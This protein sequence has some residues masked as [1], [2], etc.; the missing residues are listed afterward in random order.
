MKKLAAFIIAIVTAGNLWS[1]EI[2]RGNIYP[3]AVNHQNSAYSYGLFSLNTMESSFR[4]I[5]V[6]QTPAFNNR[7]TFFRY[8]Y[9]SEGRLISFQRDDV[10]YSY[11]YNGNELSAV[12]FNDTDIYFPSPYFVSIRKGGD[13]LLFDLEKEDGGNLEAIVLN[14]E[15]GT[16]Y[17]LQ[18]GRLDSVESIGRG[19]DK[20]A[21]RYEYDEEG[22]LRRYRKETS[23]GRGESKIVTVYSFSYQSGRVSDYLY[24]KSGPGRSFERVHCTFEYID[25][26]E[27]RIETAFAT[28]DEGSIVMTAQYEYSGPND[29]TIRI[30]DGRN[31]LMETIEVTKR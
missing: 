16:K 13:E 7:E 5:T 23:E 24:E 21:S 29:Y 15:N 11:E 2:Y 26:T 4:E 3:G 6:K 30:K 17:F 8:A 22:Q 10:S 28:D 9:D 31:R 19:D 27:G 20:F 14:D 18:E 25:N 1:Y 12:R